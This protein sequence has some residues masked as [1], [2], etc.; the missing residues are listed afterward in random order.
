M[1]LKQNNGL[2][3]KAV[4]LNFLFIYN[5]ATGVNAVQFGL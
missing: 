1:L 3:L 2:G 4:L 5:I